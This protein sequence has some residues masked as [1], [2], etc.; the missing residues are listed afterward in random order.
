MA[1]RETTALRIEGR[2]GP[3]LRSRDIGLT[4]DRGFTLIEIIIVIAVIGI[5]F[6][7]AAPAY[8]DMQ[9]D[10]K[11]S[12]CKSALGGLRDGISGWVLKGALRTGTGTFPAIDSLRTASTVMLH[13]IPPNPFQSKNSAPDSIVTGVTRGVIVGTRGGWAYKSS[14]GEIWPNTHTVIGGSGCSGGTDI[15]ENAW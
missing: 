4:D 5:I 3:S 13:N 14:T 10:A 15:G 7:V 2:H 11:K 9:L 1:N 8:Q 12:A 6:S